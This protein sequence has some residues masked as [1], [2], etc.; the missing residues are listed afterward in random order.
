MPP[1][2]IRMGECITHMRKKIRTSPPLIGILTI[3]KGEK[4]LGNLPLFRAMIKTCE[5]HGARAAV[6]TPADIDWEQERVNAFLY[7]TKSHRFEQGILPM[8]DVIYNRIPNRSWESLPSVKEALLRLR[9][10]YGPRFFNPSFF[11]KGEIYERVS[12]SAMKGFLPATLRWEGEGALLEM[13]REH[14]SLYLKPTD[15]R[16]G[17]GIYFLELREAEGG[18][19]PSFRLRSTASEEWVI[20]PFSRLWEELSRR[21][22]QRPYVIQQAVK[23]LTFSGRP[24]DLRVLL[25]KGGDGTWGVT[26]V[27]ARLAGADRITTHVPQGGSILSPEEALSLT[28][29]RDERKRKYR[30]IEEVSLGIARAIDEGDDQALGEMSMD[31]GLSPDGKLW[32]FEANAK[33]MKFDEP[34]IHRRSLIRRTQYL[35]H[36]AGRKPILPSS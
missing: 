20:L 13:I 4:L 28:M 1:P 19:E 26:G 12:A 24:F 22:G 25:Q 21:V 16:A 18:G 30:E 7:Q 11:D 31:L 2:C 33:P 29:T 10:R 23:R 34:S 3:R 15:G 17:D 6:F 27:G 5:D 9:D 32:F 14:P 36:L 8:L 35:F